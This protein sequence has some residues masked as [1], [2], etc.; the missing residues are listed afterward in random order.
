MQQATVNDKSI[1]VLKSIP[2]VAVHLAAI[3]GVAML[4]WSWK[5]L[6]LAVALSYARMFFVTAGYHRYFSHR[7]FR[8]SPCDAAPPRARR[9]DEL[10]E[11]GAVVVGPP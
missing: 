2:F 6:G 8:T 4:G 7:S 1:D 9:D 5:G 11:R 10:A 3:V